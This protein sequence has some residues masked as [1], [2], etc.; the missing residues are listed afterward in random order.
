MAKARVLITHNEI[1]LARD[2]AQLFSHEGYEAITASRGDECL[3]KVYQFRPDLIFCDGM[4]IALSGF[5]VL[6]RLRSD[7]NTAS[8]LFIFLTAMNRHEDIRKGMELGADDYLTLPVV[9][10]E[11]LSA[12][13][14]R[15]KRRAQ[16]L[17]LP[18]EESHI[19]HMRLAHHVF[20]SYSR[21]DTLIMQRVRNDMQSQGLRVWTDEQL[22]P[23]TP[24]WTEGI[25]TA[26]ENTGCLVALLSPDAKQSEWVNQEIEYA[27]VH[28]IPIFSVIVRGDSRNAVPINL[29]RS[30]FTDVRK[31]Y[32]SEVIKLISAIRVKVG[33]YG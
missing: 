9:V 20:L 16:L 8:L 11:L 30:Q 4:M 1:I 33:I 24:A 26:I 3:E 29:I 25:Q 27:K 12:A 19:L 21:T 15:L 28:Q 18:F 2:F 31:N 7:P 14:A 32:E 23:G 17:G 5:E 22:Q 10:N 13:A 6:E